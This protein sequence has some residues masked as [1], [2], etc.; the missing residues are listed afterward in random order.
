M[1]VETLYIQ[2]LISNTLFIDKVEKNII[3]TYYFY[4]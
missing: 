1:A 4:I 3:L 2:S